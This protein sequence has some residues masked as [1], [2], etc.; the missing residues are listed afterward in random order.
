M[1]NVSKIENRTTY[2]IKT[3]YY[4]ELVTPETMKLPATTKN[5]I[6]IDKNGENVLHAIVPNKSFSQLLDIL[7]KNSIF[8]ETFNSEFSYIENWFTDQNFKPLEIEHK[9]NIHLIIT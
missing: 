9:I 7:R 4:L 1:I 6:T 5:K 3:R 8:L 2:K